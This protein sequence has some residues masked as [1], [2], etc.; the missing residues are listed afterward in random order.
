MNEAAKLLLITLAAFLG[1]FV[2]AYGMSLGLIAMIT[3]GANQIATGELILILSGYTKI[4]MS[5]SFMCVPFAVGAF[6]HWLLDVYDT[7]E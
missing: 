6:A 5:I 4:N 1:G 2:L 3:T 7:L